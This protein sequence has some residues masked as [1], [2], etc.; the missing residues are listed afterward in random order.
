MQKA[1]TTKDTLI[2]Q[3]YGQILLMIGDGRLKP[4][5]FIS[6]RLLAEQLKVSKQPIG[7]ALQ[8]L[9]YDGVVESVPR[10]GTRVRQVTAEDMWGML[11]WR[12]GLEMRTA[13]LAAEYGEPGEQK[14]LRRLAE[15]LDE[16][17]I[18]SD[19]PL[20]AIRRRDMDFHL[21]LA[22]ASH[23]QRLRQELCKLNIY[24]LKSI[25]CEAVQISREGLLGIPIVRHVEIADAIL[26]RNRSLAAE[27]M[28]KHIEQSPDMK[29]FSEWYKNNNQKTKELK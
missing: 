18:K 28:E 15:I 25:L 14:E 24:Y 20:A 11:Q 5:E 29:K 23:C 16:T 3:S 13:T 9:E 8:R 17:I 10:V 6:H 7:V 1:T 2:E 22:E 26:A 4:S 27:L 12:L 21:A 19:C